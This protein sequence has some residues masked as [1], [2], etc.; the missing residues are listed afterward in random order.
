MFFVIL[1]IVFSLEIAY[2][3][4]MK[5]S[6][7]SLFLILLWLIIAG[8]IVWFKV[9]PL[10]R[11]TYSVSYPQ[12]FNFLGGKGFIGHLTPAERVKVESNRMPEVIGDPVYFSV[13]TPRTFNEAKIT[14]VYQDNLGTST[15]IIETGVLVDNVIWRYKL[16]PLE[17][18]WFSNYFSNWE[19]ISE[20]GNLLLQKDDNYKTVSDFLDDLKN[21]PEKIC[22]NGDVSSCVVFYNTSKLNN[23]LPEKINLNPVNNFEPINIPLQG[24]HQFYFYISNQSDF[25]DFDFDITDLNLDKKPDPVTISVYRGE[26]KI[27]STT[28]AD[29]NGLESSGEVRNYFVPVAFSGKDN[30]PGLYK[31]E[32]KVSDDI[33]IKKIS[34]APAALNI[35]G[36]LHPVKSAKQPIN[37]WTSNSSIKLTTNNPASLQELKYGDQRF[38]LDEAYKQFEFSNFEPGVKKISLTKDDIFLETDGVFS[39]SPDSFFDPSFIEVNQKYLP[40]TNHQYVLANYQFPKVRND[41]YKEASVVLDTKEAY[42][43]RGKYSFMIS[44][45]GLSLA[46]QG[47][48]LI[49]EIRI[50]FS[51]RTIFDKIKEKITKYV[52]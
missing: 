28:I 31:L 18:K 10:G 40:E 35:V 2:N 37:L 30:K 24:T 39:F 3:H 9:V 45:P 33:V 38:N 41:N 49:K 1:S 23:Y 17:N 20:N 4:S 16:A 11:A 47:N 26:E 52:N 32:I 12:G 6:K 22:Q 44:V 36:K 15:P 48:L 27:Y 34:K 14:I 19:K 42:R 7:I 8:L 46:N 51:G 21:K 25:L 50:D 29:N 13:F 5:L 43:E